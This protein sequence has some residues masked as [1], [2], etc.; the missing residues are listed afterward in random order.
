MFKGLLD[1]IK[2][3]RFERTRRRMLTET[4]KV[5]MKKVGATCVHVFAAFLQAEH[6][7]TGP[8]LK[9]ARKSTAG[10]GSYPT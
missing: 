5:I 1:K 8:A 7:R 3:W 2:A 9:R 10:S 4:Y 6:V